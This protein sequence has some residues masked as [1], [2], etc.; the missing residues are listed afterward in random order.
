MNESTEK[1]HLL[2]KRMISEF[3]G[4]ETIAIN[5]AFAP[6]EQMLYLSQWFQKVIFT[7]ASKGVNMGQWV[8]F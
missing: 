4:F 2:A 8:K 5:R 1:E 3:C 6:Q 7:V